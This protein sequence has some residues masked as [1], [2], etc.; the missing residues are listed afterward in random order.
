MKFPLCLPPLAFFLSNLSLIFGKVFHNYS[1]ALESAPLQ[2][3]GW[4][5]G[6]RVILYALSWVKIFPKTPVTGGAVIELNTHSQTDTDIPHRRRRSSGCSNS[7]SSSAV[8]AEGRSMCKFMERKAT[9][10][11][12]GGIGASDCTGLPKKRAACGEFARGVAGGVVEVGAR[13]ELDG[14]EARQQFWQ[15]ST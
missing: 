15:P 11:G 13:M 1:T 12:G 2:G 10:R 6:R 7:S 4:V 9:A 5:L 8:D 3:A 14:T